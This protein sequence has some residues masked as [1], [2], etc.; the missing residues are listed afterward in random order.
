MF[1]H[2]PNKRFYKHF[3]MYANCVAFKSEY[4]KFLLKRAEFC[5]SY[6]YHLIKPVGR[7]SRKS[8]MQKLR[9]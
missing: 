9:I 2:V 6:Y 1:L 4:K 5:C 7:I 3:H 8:Q